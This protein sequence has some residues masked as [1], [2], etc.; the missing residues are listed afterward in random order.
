ME[1]T[2]ITKFITSKLNS[3]VHQG[4]YMFPLLYSHPQG[5]S[6]YTRRHIQL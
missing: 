2:C 1:V 6:S 4:S 5:A 3:S